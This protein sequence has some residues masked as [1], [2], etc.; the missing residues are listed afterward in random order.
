M[1]MLKIGSKSA[2]FGGFRFTA[3][4]QRFYAQVQNSQDDP[5]GRNDLIPNCI[6]ESV[7]TGVWCVPGIGAG[8]ETALGPSKLQK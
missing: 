3:K 6:W 7:S 2:K 1:L 5:F 4:A 8:F